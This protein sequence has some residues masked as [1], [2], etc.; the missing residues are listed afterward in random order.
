MQK[1]LVVGAAVMDCVYTLD[2]LPVAAEKFRAKSLALRGGGT[3]ATAAVTARRLGID[4]ALAA[5]IGDDFFGDAIVDE[6]QNESVDCKLV[7]KCPGCRSSVSAVMIDSRGERMLVNFKDS[8]IDSGTDWLPQKLPSEIHGVLGDHHWE[9]GTEHLFRLARE[10]GKPAIL[11]ADRQTSMSI[12][13]SATHIG[14]SARGLREQSG[15]ESLPEALAWCQTQVPGWLAV[16]DGENGALFTEEGGIAH[17]PALKVLAVDTNGAGDV[18]HGALAVALLEGQEP[19][20]AVRFANAA[21]SIK[22]SR[23]GG[24]SAIPTQSEV[25]AFL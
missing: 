14:F 6:L 9:A 18:W 16:T 7:R 1:L 17:E 23:D 2:E 24:R 19:R 22:C 21:A 8:N 12:L 3:A 4:V 11:D 13:A 20:K 5:R 15:I 25:A 10:A